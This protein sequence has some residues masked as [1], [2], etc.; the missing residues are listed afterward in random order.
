M[1]QKHNQEPCD[2]MQPPAIH[3]ETATRIKTNSINKDIYPEIEKPVGS[4]RHIVKLNVK[5]KLS[6]LELQ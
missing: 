4:N 6:H 5:K 2:N 3:H 1:V